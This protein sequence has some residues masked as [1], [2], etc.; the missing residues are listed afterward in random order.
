MQGYCTLE[1]FNFKKTTHLKY[2]KVD[3]VPEA[4]NRWRGREVE[5]EGRAGRVAL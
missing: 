2:S 3:D 5:P 4:E 1:I